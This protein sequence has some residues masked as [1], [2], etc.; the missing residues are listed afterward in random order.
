MP[1][2]RKK[3]SIVMFQDVQYI[4]IDYKEQY[5]EFTLDT[6]RFSGIAEYF[7]SLRNEGMRTVVILVRNLFC[8]SLF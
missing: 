7:T 1:P 4:D 5:L 3:S 6:Q 8:W 2:S